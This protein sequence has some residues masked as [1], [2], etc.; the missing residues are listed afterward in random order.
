VAWTELRRRI[1]YDLDEAG[2][3]IPMDFWPERTVLRVLIAPVFLVAGLILVLLAGLAGL[4]VADWLGV[5]DAGVERSTRSEWAMLLGSG[6]GVIVVGFV[7]L[8]VR[9][10]VRVL[11]DA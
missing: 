6:V 8:V 3:D 7:A 2:L 10:A 5:L 1:R 4:L 11:R 9:S